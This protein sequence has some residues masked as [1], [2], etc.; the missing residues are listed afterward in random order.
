MQFH[1]W[2]AQIAQKVPGLNLDCGLSLRSLCVFPVPAYFLCPET[3]HVNLMSG[4]QVSVGVYG[5]LPVR[6][7]H[8][9]ICLDLIL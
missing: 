8:T 2:G 3:M 6:S 9:L 7:H 1:K 5:Y 4:S